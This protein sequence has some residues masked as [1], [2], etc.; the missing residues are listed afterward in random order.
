MDDT[1]VLVIEP[2]LFGAYD[3]R[4]TLDPEKHGHCAAFASQTLKSEEI[5]DALGKGVSAI[6]TGLQPSLEVVKSHGTS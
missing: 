2:H 6:W 1:Y 3:V 4:L 5:L